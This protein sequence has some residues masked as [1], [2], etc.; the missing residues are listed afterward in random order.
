MLGSLLVVGIGIKFACDISSESLKCICSAD[1]L[2][3]LVA[4]PL[5]AKWLTELNGSSE[6]LHEFYSVG[7]PR[8]ISYMQMVEKVLASVRDGLNVCMVSY[9]HPGVFGFPMHEAVRQAQAEG[10]KA[11]M[12]PGISAEATLYADLG[13]DP[14]DT[15][16]QSFEATDFLVYNRVFDKS[17]LLIL[18]QIG[19]IG[20][21]DYKEQFPQD[22]LR[23]LAEYLQQFYEGSQ[24]V[25][26]YEAAQFS[27]AKP[28]IQRTQLY[29]LPDFNIVPISTLC[30]PPKEKRNADKRMLELLGIPN[31]FKKH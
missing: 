16:C 12:L 28:K 1:K 25:I 15:G 10:F 13:F 5:S 26:I 9:G 24:E 31:D 11:K 29:R 8:K 22:G 17:S 23:I 30:I 6:S 7:K 21:I 3:Y 2:F 4:D 27:F 18:W 20:S 14:G 19:V